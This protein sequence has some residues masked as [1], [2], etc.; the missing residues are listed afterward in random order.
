M[1]ELQWG[2]NQIGWPERYVGRGG[3]IYAAIR[4]W[5]SESITVDNAGLMLTVQNAG[6]STSTFGLQ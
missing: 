3:D 6:G 4:N 5:G 2:D 1:T